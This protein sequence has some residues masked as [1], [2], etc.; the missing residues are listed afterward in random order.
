MK[1]IMAWIIHLLNKPVRKAK[2]IKNFRDYKL[3]IVPDRVDKRDYI[4]AII[5]EMML[6][7]AIN[8]SAYVT[9]K[10]QGEIGSC[11]SHAAATGLEMIDLLNNAR[12]PTALSEQFHYWEVRQPKFFNTFPEDSGQD[13]RSA[14]AVMYK[15]GI[16]PEPL[17]PYDTS[18]YNNKPGTWCTVFSRF[19]KI[20][21]YTRCTTIDQIKAALVDKDGVWLGIPVQDSIFDN[22][23]SVLKWIIGVPSIG[24]H[25]MAIVGYDNS[26]QAF[27]VVNSW[28]PDWGD[29][30][31]CWISYDYLTSVPWMDCWSFSG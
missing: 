3:D 6:P 30:G 5:P 4:K 2:K 7:E 22:T 11:G 13:G 1:Q 15:L 14:M 24:G 10:Q 19:W 20:K 18:K 23:G 17:D 31:F 28:G 21:K 16:C 12:W 25:A 9:I 26:K 29:K 8:Y 27:R